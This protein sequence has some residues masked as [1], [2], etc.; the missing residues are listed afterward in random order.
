E[1]SAGYYVGSDMW[2]WGREFLSMTPPTPRQLEIDKHW[3]HVLLW[4]RLGYDPTLDDARIG[5]LV[6]ERFPGMPAQPLLEAWQDASMVYPL[7]TG[8]HWAN[9][10]FHWYIEGCRSRPGPAKTD[11]GFH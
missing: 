6:A 8:C 4:G 5:E 11:S 10:D 9:F 7:V 3:L 1:V 2:V